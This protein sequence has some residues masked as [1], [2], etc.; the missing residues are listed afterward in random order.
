MKNLKYIL[1]ILFISLFFGCS[2]DSD[3]GFANDAEAP[4]NISA[5]FT[6]AQDNSG[7]VTIT[8]LGE[9]ATMFEVYYGDGTTEPGTATVGEKVVHQYTQG[10]FNV[11]IIATG[12]N[13]KTT[14]A[15]IPLTV[16]FLPPENLEINITPSAGNPFEIE[17]SATADL[18]L[19]FEATFGE[20][21]SA[22]PVQFMEGET[23]THTYAAIGTYTVT[24]T[25]YSGGTETVSVTE[26]VVISNPLLL[27][28]DFEDAT[29]N[30]EF[31]TFGGATASVA[32]NPASGGI[33]TSS[34]VG[35]I[36]PAQGTTWTGA[37]IT[38][39]EVI[40]MSQT[41][42]RI[43]VYSPAAGVPVLLKL[44]NL[45]NGDIS[46]ETTAY[47]TVANQWETL[48][49]TFTGANDD[50]SKLVLFFNAANPGTGD[51]YYFDDIEQYTP[52]ANSIFPITFENPSTNYNFEDFQGAQTSVV[53]N[54]DPSGINTSAKV[55]K[56]L[57]PNGSQVWAGSYKTYPAPFDFTSM[58]TI[59]MK[60]YSP[61]VGK[62]VIFKFENGTEAMNIEKSAYT[63][64]AN[65][66]EELT[67]VFDNIVS[68]NNYKTITLFFDAGVAG[69]GANYYF[70]DIQLTN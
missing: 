58:H 29:Q 45:T 20:D 6:I 48:T 11:K 44:E 57:K 59:K 41:S 17:I 5:L 7:M 33:N 15:E 55:G 69:N 8:P 2:E 66:W 70:D 39:D 56:M 51:T 50:Y 1:S 37:Y 67:F 35:S 14:E 47:T 18:E 16:S 40:D 38:L 26:D 4:S 30:Y 53:N 13:G 42:F 24:V 68:A 52:A 60:V 34:K 43:K 62:Q 32:D 31:T 22:T 28:I 49:F 25:A 27:P 64:V 12:I 9:G 19:Y 46:S 65:Q 3:T 10:T 61:A 21:P 23:I 63:T 36:T 54:P